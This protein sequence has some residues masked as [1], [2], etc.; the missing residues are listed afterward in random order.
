LFLRKFF[1][2][3]SQNG[4]LYFYFGIWQPGAFVIHNSDRS[5]NQKVAQANFFP[6]LGNTQH[7]THQDVHGH[8]DGRQRAAA[9]FR[10]HGARLCSWTGDN[11]HEARFGQ[12]WIQFFT[13][14]NFSNF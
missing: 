6:K 10:R 4:V 13:N 2:P 3:A 5:S 8:V 9:D 7:S 1:I 11:M 12:P 14:L